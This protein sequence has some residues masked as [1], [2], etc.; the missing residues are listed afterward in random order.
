ME[1]PGRESE[2]GV[3][4]DAQVSILAARQHGVVTLAQL[5]GLGLGARAVQR[6]AS[7][8][9]LHRVHRGVYALAP[10]AL[11]T[12]RGRWLAAVFACGPTAAL[13]SR[14]AA[15][16][17]DLRAT[18]RAGIDV[19][20]PGR[21]T[22]RYARIDVHRSTTLQA[23]ADVTLVDGIP[24]TTIARTLLDLA[25]VV[26]APAVERALQ[27]AELRQRLD[28]RALA[29]QL[30]RNHR[31]PGAARLRAA[32]ALYEPGT[33][34]TESPLEDLLVAAC[35][36]AGV[37]SPDR[38]VHIDPGDGDLAPRVDFAWPQQRLILETDGAR[39]H[40]TRRAFEE[41]RRRDQRLT[42]AGWQVVRVTDRQLR[43]EPRRIA[44]M[45]EDLLRIRPG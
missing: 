8:G 5:R 4:L 31:H 1:R 39:A 30:Q 10:P 17:H 21:S 27:Q 18:D 29:D 26:T 35:R 42:L 19:I 14:S 20:L 28:G 45:L 36:A 12:G 23:A 25:A 34:P 41:D 32:L 11:L 37:A 2:P 13:A 44:A 24:C 9:R 3:R 16:L 43:T 6:R 15:A 22:R 33:A 38:Q 40:R 7:E